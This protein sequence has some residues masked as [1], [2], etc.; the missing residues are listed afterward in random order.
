[1]WGGGEGVG[2]VTVDDERME[3]TIL[4][5]GGDNVCLIPPT[6]FV[7]R[8]CDPP[9]GAVNNISSNTV[10][11]KIQRQFARW[12]KTWPCTVVSATRTMSNI[13]LCLLT[14]KRKRPCA[15]IVK[16]PGE[17]GTYKFCVGEVTVGEIEGRIRSFPLCWPTN[18]M[19]DR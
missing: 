18:M 7:M 16:H 12:Q 19:T 10:L 15:Y 8:S 6:L 5:E 9:M 1:M 13:R 3:A 4:V 2:S 14:V 11:D 17:A